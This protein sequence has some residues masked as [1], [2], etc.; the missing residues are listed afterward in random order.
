MQTGTI[1]EEDNQTITTKYDISPI[2]H[3]NYQS[4]THQYIV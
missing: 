4:E 1:G 3:K 2:S